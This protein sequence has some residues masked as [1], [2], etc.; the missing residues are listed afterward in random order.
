[1]AVGSKNI[2]RQNEGLNIIAEQEK[3]LEYHC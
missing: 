3:C 2:N 1:M